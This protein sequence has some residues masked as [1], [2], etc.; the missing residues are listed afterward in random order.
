LSFL[1]D[2][3]APRLASLNL[4]G[5][6]LASA[7]DSRE[8]ALSACKHLAMAVTS[9]RGLVNLSL[10][11]VVLDAQHTAAFCDDMCITLQACG[12]LFELFAFE[13][14]VLQDLPVAKRFITWAF[15]VGPASQP[16]C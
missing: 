4:S 11:A 1:A 2:D 13:R 10:N 5:W 16:A 6:A 15:Q 12:R 9:Q 14:N 8:D 7:A 3:S